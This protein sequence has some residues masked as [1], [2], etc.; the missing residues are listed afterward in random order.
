MCNY[1]SCLTPDFVSGVKAELPIFGPRIW[2]FG[3]V[4]NSIS[5]IN[6]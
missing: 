2:V 1:I 4:L 3:S 6:F 5:S